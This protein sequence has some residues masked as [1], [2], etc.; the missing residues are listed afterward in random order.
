MLCPENKQ[1]WKFV[2]IWSKAQ[3][4]EDEHLRVSK[5]STYLRTY[6][7]TS[8][9][10]LGP[11]WLSCIER[12]RHFR[13]RLVHSSMWLGLQAVSSLERFLLSRVPFILRFHC[14]DTE[15]LKAST[16]VLSENS[17][18][19]VCLLTPKVPTN[20]LPKVQ[21][22]WFAREYVCPSSS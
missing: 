15:A 16:T 22:W 10:L 4:F 3:M 8:S 14:I 11:T 18:E 7:G 20:T 9:T 2:I 12:Y 21:R 5:H 13:G 6:S 19:F 17:L 1:V